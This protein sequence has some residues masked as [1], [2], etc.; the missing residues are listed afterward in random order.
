MCRSLN[1]GGVILRKRGSQRFQPLRRIVEE[2]SD[3]LAKQLLVITESLQR[4]RIIESRGHKGTC[5]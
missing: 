2:E 3:H 1:L 5:M 4:T